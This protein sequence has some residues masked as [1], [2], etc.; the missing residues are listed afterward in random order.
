MGVKER[1]DED[2]EEE[3]RQSWERSSWAGEGEI[4]Q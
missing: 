2:E 3:L 4:H 1:E